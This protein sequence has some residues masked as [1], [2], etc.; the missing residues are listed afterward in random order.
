MMSWRLGLA[1][2]TIA[3]LA[4]CASTT[5][6]HVDPSTGVISDGD[7]AAASP[8]GSAT[9]EPNDGGVTGRL[10]FIPD[11]NG[12]VFAS[13]RDFSMPNAGDAM[14]MM[15]P[16]PLEGECWQDFYGFDLGLIVDPTRETEGLSL[17]PF[18]ELMQLG[19]GP[20]QWKW[21][22]VMRVSQTHAEDLSTCVRDVIATAPIV[23]GNRITHAPKQ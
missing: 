4:G 19:D 5:P 15:V 13:L 11:P 17:G 8:I 14:L 1:A 7:W 16:G 23:W 6:L 22:T 3:L 20:Q 12:E 9:F 18:D 10:M 2:S 21:L